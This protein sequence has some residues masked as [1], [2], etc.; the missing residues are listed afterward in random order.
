[1]GERS[2]M[3][4]SV[5]NLPYY[6]YKY[7]AISSAAGKCRKH[8]QIPEI[9]VHGLMEN[10]LAAYGLGDWCPV[11]RASDDTTLEVTD[12]LTCMDICEKSRPDIRGDW[13]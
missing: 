10:G 6:L 12:T 9:H 13:Q 2:G 1:M 7:R 8:L 4:V 3:D 11:D 5:V